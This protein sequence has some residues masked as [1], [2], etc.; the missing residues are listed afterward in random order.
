LAVLAALIAG[1][2]LVRIPVSVSVRW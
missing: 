2:V 1:Q